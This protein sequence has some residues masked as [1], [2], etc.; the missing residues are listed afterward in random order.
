MRYHCIFVIYSS[1]GFIKNK[2]N[3]HTHKIEEALGWIISPDYSVQRVS[4]VT[5][6]EVNHSEFTI[7]S[8]KNQQ[9][10]GHALEAIL[11]PHRITWLYLGLH[12]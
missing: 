12:S 3:T 5:V 10:W 4:D 2:K 9:S 8:T 7:I 6:E 1:C 11:S